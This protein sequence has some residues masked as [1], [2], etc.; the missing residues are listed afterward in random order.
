MFDLN[1]FLGI[2]PKKFKAPLSEGATST[3]S[4]AELLV[5][6]IRAQIK[7]LYADGESFIPVLDQWLARSQTLGKDWRALKD[8]KQEIVDTAA[9]RNPFSPENMLESMKETQS[10]MAALREESAKLRQAEYDNY[11]WQNDAGLMSDGEY[12][13]KATANFERLKAEF[14]STGAAAENFLL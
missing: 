2:L 12:L 11:A 1:K 4:A 5:E 3:K 10:R 14:A 13:N 6:N 8:L 7:Y 9:E